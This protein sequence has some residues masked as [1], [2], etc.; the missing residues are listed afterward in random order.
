MTRI[1]IGGGIL[2][3]LSQE[4]IAAHPFTAVGMIAIWLGGSWH[5]SFR[6]NAIQAYSRQTRYP[7]Q[8]KKSTSPGQ[9]FTA[10]DLTPGKKYC[11]ITEFTDYYG[12][13]HTTGE[14]WEFVEKHFLPQEDGLTLHCK[15][16]G[17]DFWIYLQ[18]RE[19]TQGMVI[20]NFHCYVQEC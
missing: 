18:W 2:L 12:N 13:I 4:L 20:D 17:Q 8:E 1:L 10:A 19:G 3:L 15:K 6:H 7:V 16:N 9:E 14:C 5:S 11:V